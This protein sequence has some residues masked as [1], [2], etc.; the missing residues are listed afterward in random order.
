MFLHRRRF[1]TA[2]C[3]ALA[4][5][6]LSAEAGPSAPSDLPTRLKESAAAVADLGMGGLNVMWRYGNWLGPGWWGGSELD[7]RPGMSPPID[8]LDAVAQKHDF[9]YQL[10]EEMGRGRPG[11]E[12]TYRLIAD[13]IAIRDAMRL[14]T[15]PRR[16]SHPPKDAAL[17]RTFV[18]RL[19]IS[20]EEFQVRIN[21]LKSAEMGRTD[22]T[23]LDTLNRV[24]DGLPDEAEFERMQYQRV[25]GWQSDYT[26]FQARKRATTTPTPAPAPGPAPSPTSRDCNQGSMMDR[27][28]CSHDPTKERH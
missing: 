24:L 1:I 11:V 23:D 28:L 20:F 14:D 4:L 5:S 16:W 27:A 6:P 12:G 9:G 8:D 2:L 26:A 22:I 3:F 7:S 15:D 18:K 19:E 17:A 13:L 10:A 25:R 21:R